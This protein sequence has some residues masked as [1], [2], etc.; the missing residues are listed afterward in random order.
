MSISCLNISYN[1]IQHFKHFNLLET[2]IM[3]L[4]LRGQL[5]LDQMVCILKGSGNF[6]RVKAEM[7]FF[8][9]FYLNKKKICTAIAVLWRQNVMRVVFVAS[10][11]HSV[12]LGA[13]ANKEMLLFIS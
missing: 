9:F 3:P 6:A 11:S 10:A 7:I 4:L 5:K 8:S 1:L 2:I 12:A 13:S